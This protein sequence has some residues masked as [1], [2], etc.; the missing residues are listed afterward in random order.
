MG[1]AVRRVSLRFVVKILYPIS[2]ILHFACLISTFGYFLHLV[3]MW[4]QYG[5]VKLA[6]L[7]GEL[8]EVLVFFFCEVAKLVGVYHAF[9]FERHRQK[10]GLIRM[11]DAL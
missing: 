7:F 3:P 10:I 6:V 5:E 11:D 1:A 2:P 4:K 8:L 9:H